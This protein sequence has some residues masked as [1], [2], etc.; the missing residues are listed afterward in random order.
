MKYFK[1]K[2]KSF[3][4][5]HRIASDA[6]GDRIP[7]AEFYFKQMRD[8]KILYSA[9]IFDYFFLESFDKKEYWE[10]KLCDVHSF[11]KEASWIK[12]WLISKKLKVLLDIFILPKFS[13]F[14]PSK[15]LYKENK[16]DYYIFQF[17][18][19]LIFEQI[20]LLFDFS[21][22]IFW[23]PVK[24]ENVIVSNK[25]NFIGEY[26]RIYRENGGLDKIIQNKKLSL[27]EPLDFFPIGTFMKDDIVSERLKNTIEE[28]GIEGFE[29]SELDYEVIV[30]K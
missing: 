21:N 1:I 2:I 7:E 25:D 16:L 17:A 9:P 15:L 30:E 14:Y 20:L 6:N 22:T 12:G 29:F 8:G 11:T 28:N 3:Y 13:Y 18:G 10:W 27:K 24:L 23:N 26:K 19:K 5:N 4:E